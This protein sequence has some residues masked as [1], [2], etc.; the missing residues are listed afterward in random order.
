MSRDAIV[1]IYNMWG[2]IIV[3]NVII[4]FIVL[5]MLCSKIHLGLYSNCPF[6]R[7]DNSIN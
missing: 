6:P 2:I 4:C 3:A 1:L 7:N 5:L